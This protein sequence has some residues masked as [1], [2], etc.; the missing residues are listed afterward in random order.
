AWFIS[1]VVMIYARMPELDARERR[2]HLPALDF[3]AARVA[4]ADAF[5]AAPTPPERL[6]I[7]MRGG[8]PV[9]RA[10]VQGRWRH[11]FADDGRAPT[12]LSRDEALAE[13]ARFAGVRADALR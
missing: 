13:A 1:G 11:V 5:A 2:A 4:P 10:I 6:R 7:G 9:Y 12:G 8:R 3:S